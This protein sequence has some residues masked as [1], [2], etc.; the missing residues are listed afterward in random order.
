MLANAPR[1]LPWIA[2]FRVKY[3]YVFDSFLLLFYTVLVYA[4]GLTVPPLGRDYAAMA[5]E[6]TDLPFLANW[7]FAWEMR[8]FGASPVP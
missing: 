5:S 6:G 1:E 4:W 8:T 7:I 3:F 2:K